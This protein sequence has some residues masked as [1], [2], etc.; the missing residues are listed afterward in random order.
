M[1]QDTFLLVEYW[2]YG[3]ADSVRSRK[4]DQENLDKSVEAF[5]KLEVALFL[6]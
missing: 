1:S 4:W 6:L 2:N 3:K 5:A